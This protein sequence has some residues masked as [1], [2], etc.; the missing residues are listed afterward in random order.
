LSPT[1][2]GLVAEAASTR[3]EQ[4]A[5]VDAGGTLDWRQVADQLARAA[6]ALRAARHSADSRWAVLGENAAAT[7]LA[8]AAGL[9]A[10]VGTVALSRQ[11][12]STEIEQ[13]CRDAGV[14]GIITGPT[15]LTSVLDAAARLGDLPVVVHGSV[16]A[17]AA[18]TSWSS[19]LAGYEPATER[20]AGAPQPLMVFTSG[21]T[22]RARATEVQWVAD[23]AATA[24]DYLDALC[25]RPHLPA[26]AHLVVGPLQHNGP[27][28]AVRHLLTGNAV[29]VMERFDAATALGLIER[30]HVTSSVMV[31][32]HFQRLLALPE[33]LRAA[34]DVSTLKFVA[35]TGSGCPEAVKRA[36]IDWL[37]PVLVES[38]GGSESGTLC[39]ITSAEWLQHPNSVGRAVP[40]YE[41]LVLDEAGEPVEA[42]ITGR[43]CFRAADGRR[44][45]YLGDPAKTAAAYVLPD[46]FTLGD[47]GHVDADGFVHVTD[48]E[49]DMVVSGGVNLYPSEVEAVLRTHPLVNDVAV[50]GIPESDL[51]EQLLALVVV[52]G[53]ASAAPEPGELQAWCRARLAGY[54]VPR[55]Y[56]FVAAL[57][58]NDM[59]KVDKRALRRPYWHGE[60]TIAG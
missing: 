56:E 3:P 4:A 16:T 35:H 7:V 40:P 51:G 26:G 41:V 46:A 58:R 8:H 30:H 15:S 28:V 33:D 17:S 29:V 36:M 18:A 22:G 34:A 50:V 48:R 27:L 24:A 19:W 38:Y 11:L 57:P 25:D 2:L 12:T 55:R 54:K 44:I 5:L 39:R 13:Q 1:L 9:L 52:A 37:G 14:G 23:G 43:L 60:R 53:S 45:S 20:P 59:Q 42:G 6:T 47:L 49:S 21:T 32:T 31:P 10:G